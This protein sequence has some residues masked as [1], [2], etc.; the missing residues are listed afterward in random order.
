MKIYVST[1]HDAQISFLELDVSESI[2]ASE[3]LNLSAVKK[4][5]QGQVGFL[6]V[7]VNGEELDG[8]YKALPM[9]YRMSH[10]ERL[11][12]YKPLFQDPKERRKKKA[13]LVKKS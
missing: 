2:T 13:Q 12:I 9:N 4:L 6:K 11:E 10:G 1:Q 3:V 5:Y 8:K 7:G